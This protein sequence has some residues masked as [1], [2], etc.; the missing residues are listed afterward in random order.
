MRMIS[1]YSSSGISTA[2][3][4]SRCSISSDCTSPFGR[5]CEIPALAKKKSRCPSSD[6]AWSTR[7]EMA[8]DEAASAVTVVN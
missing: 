1:V 6:M 8:L 3:R 4:V 7:P 5:S 2:V